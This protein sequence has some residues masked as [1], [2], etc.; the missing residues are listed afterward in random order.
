MTGV[1]TCALPISEYYN[2]KDD[3]HKEKADRRDYLPRTFDNANK[4]Q[5]VTYFDED[6]TVNIKNGDGSY[7]P[8]KH[9]GY[10][11][12]GN[13]QRFSDKYGTIL[14]FNH[15]NNSW[16]DWEET[17]WVY[18]TTSHSKRLFN[19]LLL[20]MQKEAFNMPIVDDADEE[21]K[22]NYLKWIDKSNG[23]HN[24]NNAL[25][26]ASAL[27]PIACSSESFDTD[28]NLFNTLDGTVELDT[29]NIREIGRAHV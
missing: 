18:D 23:H 29:I 25:S 26:E 17:K 5:V 7:S 27:E 4:R 10:N 20:D 14:R 9:Y 2:T 13:A 3:A 21:K 8:S 22:K 19:E 6:K 1:Q 12:S 16:L 24:K 11:D 28:P 15:T